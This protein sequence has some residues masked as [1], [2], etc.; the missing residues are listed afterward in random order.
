M[1]IFTRTQFFK[2]L[3]LGLVVGVCSSVLIFS[4]GCNSISSQKKPNILLIVA[5]DMGWA[6]IGYHNSEIKTPNLDRLAKEGVDL[7]QHYVQPQCT[8]TRVSL[9]T[10]RYPNRFGRHCTSASNQ[11]AFPF[12]TITM[13]SALKSL[14]YDTAIT[15]K[16][17]LGSKPEWG[18]TKYGF[19]QS[20]GSLAGA[21]GMYDHRYR[22]NQPEFTQTWHRNDQLIEDEA[23]HATDLCTEQA[24]QWIHSLNKPF[25]L[26]V[27]FHTVHT[28]L[29][30]PQRYLD[31]NQHI[32][33]PDRRLMA[34]ALSHMDE[35][36]GRVISA[37]EETVNGITP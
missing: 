21:I 22:L 7:D 5:D 14:G 29:A 36:M 37:L 18:P 24:V 10:G 8:P 26:Y 11:Q 31:M 3:T 12:D 13:A 20:Y 16:W 35:S 17:H 30:E 23:G 28:P 15:G 27:P 4:D 34:A 9:M 6:D 2:I 1:R 32:E 33:N 25:F 19:N